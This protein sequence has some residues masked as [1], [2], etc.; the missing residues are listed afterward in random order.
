MF[1]LIIIVI[2]NSLEYADT[3]RFSNFFVQHKEVNIPLMISHLVNIHTHMVA[4]EDQ[5]AKDKGEPL[6][7]DI[8]SR[9]NLETNWEKPIFLLIQEVFG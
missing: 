2:D 9:V 6:V 1:N 3:Q 7:H 5:E 8:W 4:V